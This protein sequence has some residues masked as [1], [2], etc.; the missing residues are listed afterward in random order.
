MS[1]N[2]LKLIQI[3]LKKS[4]NIENDI[5]GFSEIFQIFRVNIFGFGIVKKFKLFD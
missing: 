4:L 1:A 3:F 5:I 2:N